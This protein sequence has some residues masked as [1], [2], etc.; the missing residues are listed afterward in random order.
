MT[1]CPITFTQI[2]NPLA[3]SDM[4]TY[5]KVA[6]DRWLENSNTSPITRQPL[7]RD[8]LTQDHTM[9]RLIDASNKCNLDKDMINEI[10]QDKPQPQDDS[11]PEAK[12][13]SKPCT[14]TQEQDITSS[15]SITDQEE[16]K[17]EKRKLKNKRQ[18]ENRKRCKEIMLKKLLEQTEYLKLKDG[19]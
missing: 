5:S 8:F 15:G 11:I 6:I 4:Q 10:R 7:Y 1:T 9:E 19:L 12:Q 3:G 13:D 18:R 17:G 16:R 14:S 2:V